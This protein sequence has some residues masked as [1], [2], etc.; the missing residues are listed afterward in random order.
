M[1]GWGDGGT[2]GTRGAGGAGGTRRQGDKETRGKN[3]PCPMPHDGRCVTV[4]RADGR[5]YNVRD[6]PNALPPQRT[7]SPMPNAQ[8]PMP[9]AQLLTNYENCSYKCRSYARAWLH[10]WSIADC[11]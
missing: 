7:A 4:G 11:W 2:R 8:C 5:C 1:G 10:F 6:L 9:N 3:A